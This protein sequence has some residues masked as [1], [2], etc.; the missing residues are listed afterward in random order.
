MDPSD[1]WSVHAMA[2]VFE[3]QCR[4]NEG[5]RFMREMQ[6]CWTDANLLHVHLHAHWAQLYLEDA[7][8]DKAV[9][10]YD[11]LVRAVRAV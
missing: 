1:A 6:D 7:E 8:V 4:R 3:V 11:A 2:H 9:R 10:R 5:L